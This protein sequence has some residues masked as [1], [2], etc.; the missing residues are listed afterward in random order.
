MGAERPFK[1]VAEFLAQAAERA[2]AKLA[3]VV[4]NP[5]E[6]VE[7]SPARPE[8]AP[9]STDGPLED[10]TADSEDEGTE[11]QGTALQRPERTEADVSTASGE[12]GENQV[13][14]KDWWAGAGRTRE[15]GPLQRRHDAMAEARAL[16]E[17]A[18]EY[19]PGSEWQA[20]AQAW[21]ELAATK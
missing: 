7:Q 19:H 5:V 8:Q 3:P 17:S 10:L 16:I 13:G 2:K 9:A 18:Q 12:P 11:Y 4:D 14:R 21:L 15:P 6:V 1:G 20:R